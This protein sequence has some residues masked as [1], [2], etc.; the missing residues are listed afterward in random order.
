MSNYWVIHALYVGCCRE[1]PYI[2]P[3]GWEALLFG[4]A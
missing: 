3:V 4:D 2:H 1:S